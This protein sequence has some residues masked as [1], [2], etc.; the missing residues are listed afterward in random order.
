MTDAV[1]L[2][3]SYYEATADSYDTSHAE[4]EHVVALHLL[5][6]Y[7]SIRGIGSVLDVGAGT[8]RA[9]RFLKTRFPHLLV[10][11]IEPV[12]ALRRRGH[13]QGIP[14]DDL[15]AG[16]GETLP[17][18]DHSFDLVCELAVLHHVRRPAALVAEI[19]RVASKMIAISD[20]NFMGQ[21][22]LWLRA[23]KY[24][25]WGAGLWRLAD[26]VKTGGKGYTYSDG[27][28]VAYSY[29]VFQNLSQIRAQWTDVNIIATSANGASYIGPITGAGHVLLVAQ[30]RRANPSA[31]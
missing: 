13:I 19:N 4:N 8:G 2:Q 5:A 30:A 29:S 17:F 22:P 14:E 6:A 31:K 10:K 3:R 26:L 1:R 12:D 27:D 23:I 20:C 11:G 9:M 25:L 15:I 7:I 18:S 16:E 21:G 28:G 24:S